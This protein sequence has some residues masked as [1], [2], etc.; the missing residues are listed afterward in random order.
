[1]LHKYELE[2]MQF[3]LVFNYIE[4]PETL[5]IVRIIEKVRCIKFEDFQGNTIDFIAQNVSRLALEC[6]ETPILKRKTTLLLALLKINTVVSEFVSMFRD[7]WTRYLD[8]IGFDLTKHIELY[9]IYHPFNLEDNTADELGYEI[10]D[11]HEYD[12]AR[13]IYEDE[14]CHELHDVYNNSHILKQQERDEIKEQI[15]KKN[16]EILYRKWGI[17]KEDE[18]LLEK[19]IIDSRF[20]DGD[21]YGEYIR[22]C[23]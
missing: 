21:T 8:L 20:G 22:N 2:A 11:D 3:I 18:E 6:K 16:R 23:A 14:V 15:M 12:D 17:I 9:I 1:M 4:I 19:H 7:K 5:Y 13:E 10:F